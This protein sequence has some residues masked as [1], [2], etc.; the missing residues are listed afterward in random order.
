MVIT[1]TTFP[2]GKM[3]IPKA[4]PGFVSE[5]QDERNASSL[6]SHLEVKNR[7]RE[8]MKVNCCSKDEEIK[9][10][11]RFQ[12]FRNNFVVLLETYTRESKTCGCRNQE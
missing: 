3:L 6:D 5:E 1:S 8:L 4:N 9:K 2:V 11:K 10:N 7:L 12:D